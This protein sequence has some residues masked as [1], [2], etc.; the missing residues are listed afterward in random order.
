MQLCKKNKVVP[1]SKNIYLVLSFIDMISRYAKNQS[2][3]DI[4][5]FEVTYG[6]YLSRLANIIFDPC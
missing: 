5:K 2:V 3:S 4:R 1:A 6:I